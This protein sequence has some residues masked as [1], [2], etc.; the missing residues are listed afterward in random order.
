MN[1]KSY[2]QKRI[3]ELEDKYKFKIPSEAVIEQPKVEQQKV[4]DVKSALKKPVDADVE[5]AA[6]QVIDGLK[7]ELEL[8]RSKTV[9]LSQKL[10]ESQHEVN[11]LRD[12]LK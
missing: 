2:Y 11:S 4:K 3:R 9:H 8:T 12:Q 5:Q 10:S 7:Q 6:Q 1:T